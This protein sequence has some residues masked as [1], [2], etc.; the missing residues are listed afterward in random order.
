[1]SEKKKA[2]RQRFRHA[3]MSRD[4]YVCRLCGALGYDRQGVPIAGCVPVDAHH[5][6]PRE[7][8]P[9]G[10]YVPENGATLCDDC[11]KKAEDPAKADLANALLY[12]LI[13]SSPAIA[14]SAAE[15]QEAR[16]AEG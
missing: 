3:V 9:G 13:G 1:M 6:T 4:D 12:R 10:G 15:Q 14:L 5:I 16:D 7:R 8:M 2:I 11:H